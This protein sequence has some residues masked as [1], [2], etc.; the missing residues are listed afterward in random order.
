MQFLEY[1]IFM[2]NVDQHSMSVVAGHMKIIIHRVHS[3][4]T[5]VIGMGQYPDKS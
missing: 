4:E 1:R 3:L 5:K 2:W